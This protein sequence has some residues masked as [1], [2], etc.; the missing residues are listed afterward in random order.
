MYILEKIYHGD[1]E[2]YP[3][4]YINIKM[5]NVDFTLVLSPRKDDIWKVQI[6]HNGIKTC[7]FC[8][9]DEDDYKYEYESGNPLVMDGECMYFLLEEEPR[10]QLIEWLRTAA[11]LRVL[12]ETGVEIRAIAE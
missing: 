7:P 10:W 8:E 11:P 5:E 3:D 2:F 12:M 9:M 4:I 1:L 6:T